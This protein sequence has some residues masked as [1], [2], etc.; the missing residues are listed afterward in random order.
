MLADLEILLTSTAVQLLAAP[1]VQV[2]DHLTG[3]LGTFHDLAKAAAHFSEFKRTC[4][5]HPL[6]A[7]ILQDP[8]SRRAY[9]KPRG[10]AGD[11]VML[12]YIYRPGRVVTSRLGHV[13]HK[14]TTQLPNAKS[15]AW[16]RDYL[17]KLIWQ[18]A[19][20]AEKPSVLSVASGHMRE[21][22]VVRGRVAHPDAI[23]ISALDQDGDS[24]EECVRSYPE[25]NIRPL[26]KSVAAL[27]KR[28]ELGFQNFDV[29]YS[30]GLA[31][32]LSDRMLGALISR[33]YQLLRPE[34][35]LT[36]AN[37][38][39]DSHG[40]GFMEGFM[41]WSLIYRN[42]RDLLLLARE[43]SPAARFETFRDGPG[44]VAYIKIYKQSASMRT[45]S[46]PSCSVF[47][48]S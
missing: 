32:Y 10:Y 18:A 33:L 8:Y 23:E 21:L 45:W 26:R 40:R 11:A 14:A 38:T 30:A 19:D 2:I 16:R 22:D 17:A 44:N 36:I 20:K 13:V 25:F 31:D 9:E 29:I 15:I 48:N 1:S 35:V 41:D 12:D 7:L 37:Y 5:A 39:P 42:E 24:L 27:I 28:N 46:G 4:Q 3:E 47:H 43:V 6:F 34:G